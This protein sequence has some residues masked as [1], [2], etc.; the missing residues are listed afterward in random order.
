MKYHNF[1]QHTARVIY[2]VNYD[3]S[4]YESCTATFFVERR[5]KTA[6]PVG[7]G[8]ECH[9]DIWSYNQWI[10]KKIIHDIML[11]NGDDL[12]LKE[13]MICLLKKFL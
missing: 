6:M 5:T 11:R 1:F 3:D 2:R 8:V 10:Y 7:P 13:I 12:L 9:K 4:S